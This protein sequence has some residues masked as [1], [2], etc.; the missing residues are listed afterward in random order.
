MDTLY[1]LFIDFIGISPQTDL[2]GFLTCSLFVFFMV[3]K[4]FVLLYSLFKR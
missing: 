4:I 2:F 1:S 3:D